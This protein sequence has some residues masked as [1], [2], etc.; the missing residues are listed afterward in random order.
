MVMEALSAAEAQLKPL[1][2]EPPQVAVVLGS[3]LSSLADEFSERQALP[4]TAIHGMPQT[5]VVGHKGQLAWG[6][7]EGVSVMAMQGRFH[8]YEGYPLD[9]VVFGVR[10][11]LRLGARV[12]MVSNAAGGLDATMAP[13]SL[14]LI[15]DHINL[16]GR[17]CLVGP[18]V[19]ALGPRFPDM[20][21]PYDRD[22]MRVAQDVAAAQGVEL[23]RGVYA[24]VLGPSYETPAEVRMLRM[25]G[26]SAVGMST[27]QEVIAAS[28]M[29]A[30][31]LG[32]SCITNLASGLSRDKLS[33][34]DVERTARAATERL[35]RLF[36][37]VLSALAPQLQR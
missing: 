37:G 27:V 33:H 1:I 19:D 10:L 8:P 16:S 9:S 28:H 18:N 20:S 11:M 24:G 12:L 35:Q 31:V 15:E 30:K 7:L 2:Q 25:L 13:G 32:I 29:G 5:T 21:E 22:L 23:A 17:N 14:M 3:G 36:R 34:Q 26:A 4:Y 6:K